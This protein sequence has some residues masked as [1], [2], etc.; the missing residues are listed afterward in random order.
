MHGVEVLKDKFDDNG[1]SKKMKIDQSNCLISTFSNTIEAA[2]L[3]LEELI[4]WVKWL[5]C[6]IEFGTSLS[7]TLKFS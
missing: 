2:I 3:D 6:I 5:K 4:W 7:N 1:S